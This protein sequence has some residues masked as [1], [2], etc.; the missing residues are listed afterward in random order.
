[1]KLPIKLLTLNTLQYGFTQ[2]TAIVLFVEGASLMAVELMG[3]KLL[4]PFYGSS[5]FVWTTILSITVLGLSAGYAVGGKYGS[6]LYGSKLLLPILLL[7]ATWVLF[8]PHI[9]VAAIAITSSMPLLAG[10]LVASIVLLVPPMVCFGL[11]GP[12][13]VGLLSAD[14][15]RNSTV[16]GSVYFVSTLGGVIATFVVGFYAIPQIGLTHTSRWVAVAL[17][18]LPVI[19]L[20]VGWFTPPQQVATMSSPQPASPT[21]RQSAQPIPRSMYGYAVVEGAAVMAVELLSARMLAPYFGASLYVWTTV[22]GITLISLAIGYFLGGKIAAKQ[23][24][25]HTIHWVLLSAAGFLV[26]MHI[27]AQYLTN[28]LQSLAFQTALVAVS[29]WLLMPPLIL[30]GMVP[31]LVIRYTAVE[32][33]AASQS[34]GYVFTLSSVAGIVTLFVLGFYI[35]PTFGLTVPSL[36]LGVLVGMVPLVKLLMQQKYVSLLFILFLSVSLWQRNPVK[37]SPDVK[38]LHFSEG[39]LG[40]VLVADVFKNGKGEPR[41]DRML[42]VNRIGQTQIDNNT[43]RYLWN[44]ITFASAVSSKLPTESDALLLGLGG[45][46]V[47]N[48]LTQQLHFKVDAVEL[49]E[50][51][52]KVAT[53]YFAL[54]NDVKVVTDDARHYLETTH[55][56]YD[57]IFFDVFKGDLPPPHVLSVECFTKAK[58]L[59]RANGLVIVNFNG[60]LSDDIGK[61]GRSVLRTLEAAG[62]AVKILATPGDEEKRNTLF[63]AT[64]QP[65]SF[66]NVSLPLMF[67]GNAVNI[68]TLFTN[69][70][71]LDR[72][73]STVFTDDVPLLEQLNIEAANSWRAGYNNTFTRFFTQNGIPLFN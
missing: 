55:K 67:K 22:I 37:A 26:C 60:F 3:A 19:Q 34:T 62:F 46:S 8:L 10:I 40:Q 53:K 13:A 4:A 44:Y 17:A 48:M 2:L 66:A 35:I 7:A 25:V 39:I 47:A 57:L 18:C 38:V 72:A 16:A 32:G 23:L 36:F 63:V 70:N 56:Q 24:S 9:A 30:L 11:V 43:G 21:K 15:P 6:S 69:P 12:M 73:T 58:T 42:F 41:N 59:L 27:S 28:A 52:A 68:D 20:C 45:G 50:R 71:R 65:Q 51:I 31:T 5:L 33:T 1:M 61:P 49:D 54:S 64:Q 29:S 14:N